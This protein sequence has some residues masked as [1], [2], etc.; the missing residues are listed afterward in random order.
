MVLQ[1]EKTINKME[2]LTVSLADTAATDNTQGIKVKSSN[3]NQPQPGDLAA[4][5]AVV[6]S[7]QSAMM[8]SLQQAAMLP[9]HSPAAAALNLQAIES[10]LAL[11]RIS[12]KTDVLRLTGRN[13]SQHHQQQQTQII[14]DTSDSLEQATNLSDV[15]DDLPI[16]ESDDQLTF[17][18]PL[19]G[20]NNENI[21]IESCYPNL[22]LN[23]AYQHHLNN[24]TVPKNIL[25]AAAS[26]S[27][28]SSPFGT[29]SLTPAN[30]TIISSASTSPASTSSNTQSTSVCQSSSSVASTIVAMT[31]D[32]LN[33]TALASVNQS[34]A[35][36][37]K[38][39]TQSHAG[40]ATSPSTLAGGQSTGGSCGTTT[41][42][43]LTVGGGNLRPKKQF[44]CKFCHRQFTKS[45]NLLIHE[46]THTDE[47]P[48]SCDICGKAF[49]RQDHLRDHR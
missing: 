13:N 39:M 1:I 21:T 18:T 43:S 11:Q 47:R 41:S 30:S 17:D 49:R 2:Q 15:V 7:L 24:E 10:Y 6:L 12:G 31:L 45:Y 19:D 48:Y 29:V 9:A 35:L 44:I 32:K 16:L 36:V 3:S 26:S 23:A 14:L 42:S 8:T 38:C 22:L 33:A 28:S 40:Q 5:A 34:A 4:A 25:I 27:N 46:R 37:K 20:I